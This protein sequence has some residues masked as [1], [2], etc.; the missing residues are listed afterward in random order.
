MLSAWPECVENFQR[1]FRHHQKV[2]YISERPMHNVSPWPGDQHHE[3]FVPE[4]TKVV[5]TVPT[6]TMVTLKKVRNHGSSRTENEL[7]KAFF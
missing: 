6:A 3:P 1:L 4:G 5:Q 2:N 7:R